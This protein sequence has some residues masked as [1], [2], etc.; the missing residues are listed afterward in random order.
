MLKKNR[1]HATKTSMLP[2]MRAGGTTAMVVFFVLLSVSTAVGSVSAT[3]HTWRPTIIDST[4]NVGRYS[5][6]AIASNGTIY[7]PYLN[8]GGRILRLATVVG[9]S[10]SFELV[11]RPGAFVGDTRLAP[12]ARGDRPIPHYDG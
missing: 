6:L 9:G 10:P 12:D 3:R 8:D 2:R 1:A 7:I 11:G 5:S 4:G